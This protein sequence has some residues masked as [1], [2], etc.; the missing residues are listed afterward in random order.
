MSGVIVTRAFRYRLEPTAEQEQL[1]V[2]TAGACRFV[3]NAAIEHHGVGYRMWL[4]RGRPAGDRPNQSWQGRSME[5]PAAKRTPGL[6]WL[7]AVPSHCLNQALVDADRAFRNFFA[8]R[9]AYPKAKR[10]YDNDSFRY[11]DPAQVKVSPGRAKQVFFPK[12]GWV[13]LS[14][15][16][17]CEQGYGVGYD[18]PWQGR[19]RNV[20]VR[21]E[22]NEWWA[23][24]CCEIE[25]GDPPVDVQPRDRRSGSTVGS[26]RR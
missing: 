10:K 25:I 4:G 7:A 16:K 14:I 18:Q 20:T 9:A 13:R 3:Y 11:P 23:S 2:R 1:F 15:S 22:G 24:F 12:A 21:R 19:L 6:E 17:R 26:S 8:G 5:L